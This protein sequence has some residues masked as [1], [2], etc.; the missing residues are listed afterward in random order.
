MDVSATVQ[1]GHRDYLF[2]VSAAALL[3]GFAVCLLLG[4]VDPS[5]LFYYVAGPFLLAA[6]IVVYAG[7]RRMDTLAMREG[8]PSAL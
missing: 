6:F 3:G 1:P 2:D 7:N 8:S 5:G 4:L